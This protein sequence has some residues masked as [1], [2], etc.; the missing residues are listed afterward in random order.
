MHRIYYR[1]VKEKLKD[2]ND[3]PERFRKKVEEML[4]EDEQ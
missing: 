2:I 1:L 4:K 3:V